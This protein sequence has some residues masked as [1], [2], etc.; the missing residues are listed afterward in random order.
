MGGAILPGVAMQARSLS[1]ETDL[2]PLVDPGWKDDPPAPIGDSTIAAIRSGLYWGAVGAIRELLSQMSQTRGGGLSPQLFL[3]GG[4]APLLAPQ[5]GPEAIAREH[6]VLE[7]I[8]LATRR[9]DT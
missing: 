4:D 1:Q 3:T 8:V 7:G 6:L 9:L 2:L 5:F